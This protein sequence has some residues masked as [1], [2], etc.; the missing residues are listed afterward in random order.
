MNGGAAGGLRLSGRQGGLS[1]WRSP[2]V[3]ES[4]APMVEGSP[5]RP[6][7]CPE[8]MRVATGFDPASLR[9]RRASR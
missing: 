5:G 9:S 6:L 8:I 3:S 1:T 7:R 4:A 2:S